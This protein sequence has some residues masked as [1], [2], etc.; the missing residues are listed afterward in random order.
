MGCLV[1]SETGILYITVFFVPASAQKI[2]ADALKDSVE[3]CGEWA[4]RA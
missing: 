2:C 3:E 1:K 4:Q